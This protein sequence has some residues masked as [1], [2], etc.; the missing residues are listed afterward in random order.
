MEAAALFY[1][2]S[3]AT[4][5]GSDV[6]AACVLTVVDTTPEEGVAEAVHVS[7]AELEAATERM[8]EVALE[9]GRAI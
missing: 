6:R 2:A 4:A 8:I 5:S 9:A 1:L 7:P 3:R